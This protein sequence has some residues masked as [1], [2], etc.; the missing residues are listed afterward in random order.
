MCVVCNTNVCTYCAFDQ[1]ETNNFRLWMNWRFSHQK[2]L[3]MHNWLNIC[4]CYSSPACNTDNLIIYAIE[5]TIFLFSSISFTLAFS[6]L[7]SSFTF[8]SISL[9]LYFCD[10]YQNWLSDR[11][12]MLWH[13][14][15]SI[16]V[17]FPS[18]IEMGWFG[19]VHS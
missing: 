16:I 7:Q 5:Q 12:T 8:G 6:L 2:R 13:G 9:N 4:K 1:F 14:I 10:G 18:S 17:F 19:I 15:H 3:Q 11:C